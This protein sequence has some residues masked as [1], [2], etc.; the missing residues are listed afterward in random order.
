M[1]GQ[2]VPHG[3]ECVTNVSHDAP[4]LLCVRHL[5]LGGRG[6]GGGGGGGGSLADMPAGSVPANLHTRMQ[7]CNSSIT[8]DE[9]SIVSWSG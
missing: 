9:S 8:A 2:R 7:L 5:S 4:P 1:A 3:C 6:G